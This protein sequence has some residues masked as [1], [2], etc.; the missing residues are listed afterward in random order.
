[1]ALL[2]LPAVGPRHQAALQD[3]GGATFQGGGGAPRG[4]V[5][6]AWLDASSRVQPEGVTHQIS[7]WVQA[8]LGEN[9]NWLDFAEMAFRLHEQHLSISTV[10]TTEFRC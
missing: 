2:H 10:S 7:G 5:H 9:L 3:P 4:G 1:M 6:P 8:V